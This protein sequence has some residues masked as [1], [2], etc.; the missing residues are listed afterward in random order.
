MKIWLAGL[1]MLVFGIGWTSKAL[2]D[3]RTR[4]AIEPSRHELRESPSFFWKGGS[5]YRG[6]MTVKSFATELQLSEAQRVRLEELTEQVAQEIRTHERCIQDILEVSRQSVDDLLTLDQTE[7]LAQLT[8]ERRAQYAERRAL[9]WIERLANE[10]AITLDAGQRQAVVAAFI[11]HEGR[12]H[13]KRRS[14]RGERPEESRTG[15]EDG[16]GMKIDRSGALR[17]ALENQLDPATLDLLIEEL[18]EGRR[19]SRRR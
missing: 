19:G 2:S 13:S 8:Q 17:S 15:R 16:P 9:S 18:T 11:D 5:G 14:R 12:G 3:A 4:P 1:V 7:H 6:L 10:K